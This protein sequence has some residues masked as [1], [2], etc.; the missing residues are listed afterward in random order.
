MKTILSILALSLLMACGKQQQST[1]QGNYTSFVN[2][3]N[4]VEFKA[5]S[6]I[7][8]NYDQNNQNYDVSDILLS[9]DT[10]GTYHLRS[11]IPQGNLNATTE[12]Q[13]VQGEWEISNLGELKLYQNGQL[14]AQSGFNPNNANSYTLNFI[15]PIDL[16]IVR[17]DRMNGWNGY[18]DL[19]TYSVI[20]FTVSGYQILQKN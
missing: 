3:Q 2:S 20:N 10:N 5:P 12:L 15:K 11:D 9:I 17:M 14:V 4:G 8:L 19:T 13:G 16:E 7:Q 6:K 1:N 18:N